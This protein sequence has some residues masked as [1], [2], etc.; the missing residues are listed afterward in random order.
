MGIMDRRGLFTALSALSLGA[1]F[2]RS[3][4]AKPEALV[5]SPGD[6]WCVT[7]EPNGHAI[8]QFQDGK[9][10]A[11]RFRDDLFGEPPCAICG[12][13]F[14]NGAQVHFRTGWRH[15]VFAVGSGKSIADLEEVDHVFDSPAILKAEGQPF[16]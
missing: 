15:V 9:D 8:M 12:G 14:E 5:A 7:C 3:A 1:L 10:F 13:R 6:R 11:E 16:R 4:E 2:A